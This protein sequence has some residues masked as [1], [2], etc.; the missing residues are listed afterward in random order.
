MQKNERKYGKSTSRAIEK[1]KKKNCDCPYSSR[2]PIDIRATTFTVKYFHFILTNRQLK[3]TF[4]FIYLFI[5]L[6]FFFNAFVKMR[7]R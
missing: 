5:F 3:Y 6:I 4:L 1:K 2:E 7:K